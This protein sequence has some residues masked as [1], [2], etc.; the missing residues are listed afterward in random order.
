VVEEL[1]R[2]W[3]LWP[4]LRKLLIAGSWQIHILHATLLLGTG[5]IAPVAELLGIVSRQHYYERLARGL[6]LANVVIYSVGAVLAIAA[7]FVTLGFFPKFFTLFFLQ[8]FWFLIGEEITFLGQLYIVL[9]YYFTFPK[10]TGRAKPLH[11]VLGLTWIPMAILQQS[12]I[13][14]FQGFGLTPQPASPFFNPGF[15]PQVS[16]RFFGNFSWAGY[17]LAAFAGIQ[18]LRHLRRGSDQTPFWDWLGSLGVSLGVLSMTFFM[19][20]SGYSWAIGTKGASPS[21]FYRMMVGPIAW[22]FQL[23]VLLIGMTLSLAGLYMWRRLARAGKPVRWVRRFALATLVFALLGAIPYYLGPS[24]ERMWVSWTI[25]LGAMRPWKYLALA[26]S[27]LFGVATALAYLQAAREGLDW[28]R[29]GK[30]AARLL[31]S[32]GLLALSMMVVMG[33]IRET[34]RVPGAIYGQM[35]RLDQVIPAGLAPQEDLH[36]PNPHPFTGP[37]KRPRAPEEPRR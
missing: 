21:A 31:I 1:P 3:E 12:Q 9:L 24:A 4:L 10:L 28:G 2:Y 19:A 22:M 18:Y 30:V 6:A 7:V 17:A 23:Q 32:V 25:P 29:G 34:A 36:R 11:I 15:I 5:T 26:G 33:A 8:F 35:N 16:H 13:I 20:L 37:S 27:S 14:A